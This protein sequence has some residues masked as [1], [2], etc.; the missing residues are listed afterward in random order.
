MHM[1][2]VLVHTLHMVQQQIEMIVVFFRKKKGRCQLLELL[3]GIYYLSA[4]LNMFMERP[5]DVKHAVTSSLSS[6]RST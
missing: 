1:D 3:D 6:G 5:K 2:T 4:I